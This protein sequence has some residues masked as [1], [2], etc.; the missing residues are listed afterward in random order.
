[1]MTNLKASKLLHEGILPLEINGK[2]VMTIGSKNSGMLRDIETVS[3]ETAGRCWPG[4]QMEMVRAV[5]SHKCL[6]YQ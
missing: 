1:M 3:V 2:E 6:T 5:L 4:C